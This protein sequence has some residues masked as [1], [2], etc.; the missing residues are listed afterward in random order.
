MGRDLIIGYM[1]L[2]STPSQS[3]VCTQ[4]ISKTLQKNRVEHD[5]KSLVTI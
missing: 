2:Y 5:K 4:I 1:I 3:L